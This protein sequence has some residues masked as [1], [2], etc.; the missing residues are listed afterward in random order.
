MERCRDGCE[1]VVSDSIAFCALCNERKELQ[2]SHI[3]PE[4][5]FKPMYDMKH[6]FHV[7]NVKG[8]TERKF[9]QKGIREKLLCRDCEQKFGKYEKYVSDFFDGRTEAISEKIN[10]MVVVSPVDSKLLRLFLLSI[11]WRSGVSNHEFFRQVSLG[12]HAETLRQMLLDEA[13]EPLWRYGCFVTAPLLN[14]EPQF[15]LMLQPTQ[16]RIDGLRVYRF[17]FGGLSWVFFVSNKAHP[18]NLELV[19]LDGGAELRFLLT[20]L[21]DMKYAAE[22]FEKMAG[23][24]DSNKQ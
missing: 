14:G 23:Y 6:R 10:N 13:V 16:S 5:L 11:L 3:I 15:D 8:K 22:A 19:S 21:K 12:V 17:V 1:R 20:D 7:Y 2:D 9:S 4:F 18:K 24:S